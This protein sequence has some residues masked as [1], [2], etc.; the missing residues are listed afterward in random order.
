MTIEHP[1]E[2]PEGAALFPFAWVTRK[3]GRGLWRKEIRRRVPMRPYAATQTTRNSLGMLHCEAI[4]KGGGGSRVA[5]IAETQEFVRFRTQ[6]PHAGNDE[7]DGL[8]FYGTLYFYVVRKK[9]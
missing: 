8:R 6:K 1:V 9:C 5:T 2:T 3:E 7:R 4:L